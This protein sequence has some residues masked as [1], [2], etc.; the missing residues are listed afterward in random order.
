MSYYDNS[1]FKPVESVASK[2]SPTLGWSI[3][4]I[5]VAVIGGIVLYYTIFNKTNN[6]KY[7]GFMKKLYDLVHY[8]YFVIDDL[9]KILYI[10]MTI[11]VT[12]LSFN[13]IGNWKFLIVLVGGNLLLRIS[14]EFL[15]LFIRLC[16]DVRELNN[17]KK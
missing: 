9:S 15:M 16:S 3:I 11:A 1:Y 6:N 10:I 17:K 14:F 13:Y 12:L 4:S 2:V 5:V 7:K 8:Q